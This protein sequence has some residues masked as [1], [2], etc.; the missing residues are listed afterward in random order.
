MSEDE[1]KQKKV[2]V[3]GDGE[4]AESIAQRNEAARKEDLAT[5][6]QADVLFNKITREILDDIAVKGAPRPPRVQDP[7]RRKR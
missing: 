5:R 1:Q 2:K 6:E 3:D 4:T 7:F